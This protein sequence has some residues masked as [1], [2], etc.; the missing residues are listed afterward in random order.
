MSR[1]KLIIQARTGS[2]RLP[3][4]MV[5]PFYDGKGIFEILLGKLVRDFNPKDIILATTE[6]QRDDVLCA[7]AKAYHIHVF[8]GSEEDVLSRFI[9]AGQTYRA[10]RIVRICADNP[11]LHIPFIHKLIQEYRD[12]DYLSF[13]FPDNT[14]TIKSHIGLFSELVSLEALQWVAL[15]TSNPH[16]HEHVTNYMYTHQELFK[17]RFLPLPDFL[18]QRT[19]VRLTLDTPE[20]FQMMQ[21][22]YGSFIQPP[23]NGEI[24][25]LIEKILASKELMTQMGEQI[26]IHEK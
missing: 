21:S 12:E 14:P 25:H 4:K 7:I 1:T 24:Q 8:R 10:E 6:H 9:R 17:V 22:L 11:F 19:D 26:K 3:Q 16:F 15:Q 20:D 23:I 5:L 13:A 2:T 18:N